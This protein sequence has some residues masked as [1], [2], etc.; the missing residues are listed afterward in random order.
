MLL[1]A[2]HSGLRGVHGLHAASHVVLAARHVFVSVPRHIVPLVKVLRLLSQKNVWKR[3][4]MLVTGSY[5]SNYKHVRNDKQHFV[6]YHRSIQCAVQ[7]DIIFNIFAVILLIYAFSKLT[8]VIKCDALLLHSISNDSVTS[9][10]IAHNC[11]LRN[12]IFQ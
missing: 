8:C 4:A 6:A 1:S 12:L 10:I 9:N 3:L 5:T 7:L 2:Q 11:Y